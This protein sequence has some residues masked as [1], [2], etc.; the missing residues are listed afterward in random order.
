MTLLT[1]RF[2]DEILPVP[3]KEGAA[4]K[5]S[6]AEL[7]MARQLIEQMSGKFAPEH[8]K[9]TCRTDLKRRVQ[10]KIRRKETHALQVSEPTVQ[11][12]PKAEVIDLMGA[13]KASLAKNK[14]RAHL[15]RRPPSRARKR[16]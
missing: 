5:A 3:A 14:A 11:E 8:F 13:P 9:D 6:Q 12:R 16:A 2:A 7:S 4:A 1:L 15:E 10:E